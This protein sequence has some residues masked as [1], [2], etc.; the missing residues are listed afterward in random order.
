[1]RERMLI[2]SKCGIQKNQ[3]DF[4]KEHILKAVEG[5]LSRLQV[6]YLDTLLLHRPDALM[7]PEDIAEAFSRLEQSGKVRYFG[8]SNFNSMQCELLQSALKQKLIANQLQLSLMHTGMVDFGINT[9]TKFEGAINR[10]GSILDYCHLHG[11]CVQ[12]W[13]PFQYGFFEGVF[14]DNEKF[15]QLNS[16]MNEIGEKYKVSKAAIAAAWL[17]RL[18]VKMQVICGTTNPQRLRDI[19]QARNI[20]L[21]RSEWYEL[22]L[23]AGNVLP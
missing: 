4:S 17:L 11:I 1:M 12:A 20:N 9:N 5:S 15:P 2:Q 10:D 6:D 22:Y 8:V 7:E 21:T 18:P 19:C 16:K 14:I 23:A 13:S 3:Y